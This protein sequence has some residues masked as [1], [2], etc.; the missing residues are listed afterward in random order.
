[1]AAAARA[2]EAEKVAEAEKAAEVAEVA[3]VV[4]AADVAA[5]VAS[6]DPLYQDV[7]SNERDDLMMRI[8]DGGP[9]R[10]AVVLVFR[11]LH[12]SVPAPR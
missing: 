12:R 11:L 5:R 1:M 9:S 2:A 6:A 3:A 7:A 10:A 8:C 4:R